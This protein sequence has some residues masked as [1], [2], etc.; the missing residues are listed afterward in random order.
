MSQIQLFNK[1]TVAKGLTQLAFELAFKSRPRFSELNFDVGQSYRAGVVC[2][3]AV[4]IDGFVFPGSKIL[5]N[6]DAATTFKSEVQFV[7][8]SGVWSVSSIALFFGSSIALVR[9]EYENAHSSNTLHYPSHLCINRGRDGFSQWEV[10]DTDSGEV[11]SLAPSFYE[12]KPYT[13]LVRCY[14][15]G[16][17]SPTHFFRR[18]LGHEKGRDYWICQCTPDV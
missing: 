4:A 2:R 11:V 7:N 6:R 15:C 8:V 9:C 14:T 13:P 5:G 1:S 16:R 3:Q 18:S 10:M 12:V 17:E